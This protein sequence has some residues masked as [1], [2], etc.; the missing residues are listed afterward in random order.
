MKYRA[1]VVVTFDAAHYIE[2]YPGKCS[3]L[4]GHTYRVEVVFERRELGEDYMVI[5]FGEA[6]R[7][8]REVVGELDHRL[9]NDVM[10]TSRPTTERIAVY[11]LE[12]VRE[13]IPFV[14]AVRVYETPTSYAEVEVED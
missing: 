1:C 9:L 8:V 14:K 6:K 2:G 7:V 13:K 5:D 12:K 11:I 3:Q 4:H 10:G